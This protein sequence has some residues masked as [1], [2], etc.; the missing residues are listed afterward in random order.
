MFSYEDA[1]LYGG[2]A[3]KVLLSASAATW[4][5]YA[6]RY[7]L[8]WFPYLILTPGDTAT[9]TRAPLRLSVGVIIG[10]LAV[11]IGVLTAKRNDIAEIADLPVPDRAKKLEH[12][13]KQRP[14]AR[15]VHFLLMLAVTESTFDA[16]VFHYDQPWAGILSVFEMTLMLSAAFFV[17]LELIRDRQ[18]KVS[19]IFDAVHLSVGDD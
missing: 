19:G 9:V 18:K 8:H 10:T 11:I 5:W 2:L 7:Q 15:V 13:L 12:V 6:I 14:L 3:L 1:R 17:G 4:A 16:A